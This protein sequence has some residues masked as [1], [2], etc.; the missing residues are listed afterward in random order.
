MSK[1]IT[2][3]GSS[4]PRSGDEEY[5]TAYRLGKLIG[6]TGFNVC[7]GGFQGIMD[8]VSKGVTEQ[9]KQAIGVT[10]NLFSVAPSKYLTKEIKC[11]SLFSRIETLINEGDAYIILSGG[12]GTLVE[13]SIVWE[14]VNKNLM[15]PKPILVHGKMWKPII[16]GID[17]RMK[18]ENRKTNLVKYIDN[19]EECLLYI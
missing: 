14:Y 13:F 1:T 8:A 6:K 12:T 18:F 9:G 11:N 4:L 7:S 19:I 2:V 5:E 10:V 3:F 17:K 16:E 15:P